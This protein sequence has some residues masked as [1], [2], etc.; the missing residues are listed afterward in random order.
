VE[1]PLTSGGGGVWLFEDPMVEPLIKAFLR[2]YL[3]E[4][5]KDVFTCINVTR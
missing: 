2:H 1:R 4:G 5:R 3:L